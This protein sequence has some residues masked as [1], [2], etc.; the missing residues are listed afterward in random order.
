MRSIRCTAGVVL[1]DA[2]LQTYEIFNLDLQAELVTLS[3]CETGLGALRRGEGLV[4]LT[5]AFMYAGTIPSWPA[6]GE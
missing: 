2:V 4:G 1:Q 3:A 5:R 6:C